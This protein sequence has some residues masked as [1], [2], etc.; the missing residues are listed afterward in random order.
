MRESRNLEL[1]EKISRS[2]LKTVSAYANYG[3]GKVLFG[4]ADDG[5]IVGVDDLDD[6]CL[7]VENAIN[8]SI[9]PVP[10]F[11]IEPNPSDNTITLVVKEGSYKPYLYKSKAYKRSDSSTVEVSR[12]ELGRL[13]LAGRNMSFDST[14]AHEADLTFNALAARLES[15]MGVSVLSDDVL[16]TLELENPKGEFNVAA[17]LLAD[18]NAFPGIDIARFGETIDIFLERETFERESVLLQYQHAVDVYRRNY[19]YEVV[20]GAQRVA[21]E[22]I[23]EAAYR[24]AIANALVHRQWDVP[25]HVR[26]AMFKDRIE[27][28]S[29]GGLPQGLSEDEYLEGQTSILRNPVLGNVF[30]RLGIIE[31]FGTGVLRIKEYYHGSEAQPLFDIF[32]N[33]IR[34]TLPLWQDRLD[35]SEDEA[36]VHSAI[37]GRSLPIGEI[38]KRVGFSK[39]KIRGILQRLAKQ[40]YIEI[41]G[42][43]RATKYRA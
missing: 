32:E 36:A 42:T 37:R 19:R 5:R 8:D 22:L 12:L 2:F 30:F 27:V 6:T 25:A 29:P 14:A 26:V 15:E 20:D 13:V 33:S 39:S 16:K 7:A 38:S 40:G 31:R 10:D 21:R 1:K 18:V 23:P 3:T 4:V 43:G 34:V 35:L 41:T 28:T 11:S 24:E 17:E 9:D